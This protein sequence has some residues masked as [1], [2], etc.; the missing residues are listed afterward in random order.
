MYN[1]KSNIA[2]D[3]I[4]HEEILKTLK[5][6]DDNKNNNELLK[7]ILGH[8][9]DVLNVGNNLHFPIDSYQ[10]FFKSYFYQKNSW[11]L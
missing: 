8:L 5:Y 2:D 9:S 7:Q 6:A 3:F 11:I 10:Q 1:P 4:S